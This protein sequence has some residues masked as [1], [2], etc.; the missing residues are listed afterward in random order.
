M[1]TRILLGQDDATAWALEDRRFYDLQVRKTSFD[2]AT[3]PF[4]NVASKSSL[5]E[6]EYLSKI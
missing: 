2:E 5:P 6:P 1:R 4:S 3:T